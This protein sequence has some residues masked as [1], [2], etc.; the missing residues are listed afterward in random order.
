MLMPGLKPSLFMG[1]FDSTL[2]NTVCQWIAAGRYSPRKPVSYINKTDRHDISVILL[3]V[4]Y[5]TIILSLSTNEGTVLEG[6][7]NNIFRT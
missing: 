5:S 4:M 7:D 1:V 6:E 2:S 3:K